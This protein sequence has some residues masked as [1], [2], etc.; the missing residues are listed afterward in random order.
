MRVIGD[1]VTLV[2]TDR[3]G[4]RNELIAD[5]ISVRTIVDNDTAAQISK[6]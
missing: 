1:V 5:L 4:C 2:A 3:I 6:V